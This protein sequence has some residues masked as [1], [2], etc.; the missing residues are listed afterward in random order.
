M[1]AIPWYKVTSH[2]VTPK[3]KLK[4]RA[5]IIHSECDSKLEQGRLARIQRSKTGRTYKIAI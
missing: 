3:D 1:T 2:N 5:E 4:G